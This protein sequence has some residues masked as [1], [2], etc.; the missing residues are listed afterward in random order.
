M[1]E[2]QIKAQ[3]KVLL[4]IKDI[5]DKSSQRQSSIAEHVKAMRN[6]IGIMSGTIAVDTV[7]NQGGEVVEQKVVVDNLKDVLSVV[8][9]GS[10]RFIRITALG[11]DFCLGLKLAE[12]GKEMKWQEAIDYCKERQ[13][14]LLTKRQYLIVAIFHD[15]IN[16]MLE[17]LGGDKLGYEWSVSEYADC[18][19][20]WYCNGR[21]GTLNSYGE[22]GSS[23]VRPSLAHFSNL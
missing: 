22:Y 7:R 23:Q 8:N 15:E 21:G 16:K 9:K 2:E 6:D 3:T 18:S 5:L 1:I 4:E 20:A 13:R 10:Q 19:S 11:E 12:D 14:D 17:D